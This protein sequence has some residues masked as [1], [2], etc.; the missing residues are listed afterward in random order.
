MIR[1]CLRQV[2]VAASSRYISTNLEMRHEARE[3]SWKWGPK[4]CGRGHPRARSGPEVQ[5]LLDVLHDER[6]VNLAL[7]EAHAQLSA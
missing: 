2:R 4:E 5:T 1:R 3:E 6:F 7:A